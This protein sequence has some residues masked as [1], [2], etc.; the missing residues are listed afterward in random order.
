MYIYIYIQ[1][2]L[3]DALQAS[4]EAFTSGV[5]LATT[6]CRCLIAFLSRCALALPPCLLT[7]SAMLDIQDKQDKQD[8][9]KIIALPVLLAASKL[10]LAITPARRV[11]QGRREEALRGV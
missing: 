5:G 9:H 1:L 6:W 10:Y 4:A 11:R 8:N 2:P 3:S 7:V